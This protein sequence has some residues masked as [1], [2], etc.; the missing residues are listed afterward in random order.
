LE[1]KSVIIYIKNLPG[2]EHACPAIWHLSLVPEHSG[3]GLDPLIPEV[4]MPDVYSLAVIVSLCVCTRCKGDERQ[5][6]P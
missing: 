6:V 2:I 1:P 3:T 5:T 4:G